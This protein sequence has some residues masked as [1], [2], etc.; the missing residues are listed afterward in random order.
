LLRRHQAPASDAFAHSCGDINRLLV[1]ICD[2]FR[3]RRT[4]VQWGKIETTSLES[5]SLVGLTEFEPATT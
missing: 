3:R 1:T 5:I 4:Y 2:N